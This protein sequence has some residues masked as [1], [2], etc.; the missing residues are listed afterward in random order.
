MFVEIDL[1]EDHIEAEIKDISEDS[2]W[3]HH[4]RDIQRDMFFFSNGNWKFRGNGCTFSGQVRAR[5]LV[6]QH[7]NLFQQEPF[8]RP[9]RMRR[10]NQAQDKGENE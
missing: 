7:G 3:T 9:A 10:R 4:F 2:N 5:F 1:L 6:N 8:F